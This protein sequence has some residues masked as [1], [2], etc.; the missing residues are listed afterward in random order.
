MG[1][2]A[3][4][5]VSPP[6]LAGVPLRGASGREV[7]FAPSMACLMSRGGSSDDAQCELPAL[8]LLTAARLGL[9][10]SLAAP[11]RA[12]WPDQGVPPAPRTRILARVCPVGPSRPGLSGPSP[13]RRALPTSRS[14]YP[15]PP[16]TRLV[17]LA[18]SASRWLGAVRAS[19]V[20]PGPRPP[21]AWV[22]T[23]VGSPLPDPGPRSHWTPTD[24]R[25]GELFK[26]GRREEG[27][28]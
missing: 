26:Q 17:A 15:T 12:P 14:P 28:R 5:A 13:L 27:W 23:R 24:P 21:G 4:S 3:G 19:A 10:P 18:S 16:G 9:G 20:G 2:A 7:A 22:W 8:T 25:R 6:L 1:V 11:T